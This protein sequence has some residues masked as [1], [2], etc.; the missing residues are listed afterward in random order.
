MLNKVHLHSRL[1]ADPELRSTKGDKKVVSFSIA[2][3]GNSDKAPVEFIPVVAWNNIAENIA[4]HLKKGSEIIIEAHI[5]MAPRKGKDDKTYHTTDIVVDAFDFCGSKGTQEK[6]DEE[7]PTD[8]T[9]D[10]LEPSL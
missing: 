10:D 3:P 6:S 7:D 4:K 5:H 8:L 9:V 2:V 1:V